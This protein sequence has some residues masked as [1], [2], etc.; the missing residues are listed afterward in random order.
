MLLP[1]TEMISVDVSGKPFLVIG[2]GFA[3]HPLQMI[4]EN[5]YLFQRCRHSKNP[6]GISFLLAD[7]RNAATVFWS[8]AWVSSFYLLTNQDLS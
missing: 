8:S 3:S 7:H 2:R 6:L 5:M 1:V 4:G